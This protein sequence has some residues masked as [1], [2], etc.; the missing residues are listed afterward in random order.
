LLVQT[1]EWS[2]KGRQ[3]TSAWKVLKNNKHANAT[4]RFVKWQQ[5]AILDKQ[6]EK[7]CVEIIWRNKEIWNMNFV[8]YRAVQFAIATGV[9]FTGCSIQYK[10]Q[11]IQSPFQT[12][13][14]LTATKSPTVCDTMLTKNHHPNF[15]MYWH[16][17]RVWR[18][19]KNIS[20]TALYHIVSNP[21]TAIA[22]MWHH[23]FLQR[24]VYK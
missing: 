6:L 15:S 13:A 14:I 23:V 7:I 5:L 11:H 22:H 3:L 21:S 10:L 24:S 18:R 16:A 1:S 20:V 12:T 17:A 19:C 9:H 8:S 2:S 4:T